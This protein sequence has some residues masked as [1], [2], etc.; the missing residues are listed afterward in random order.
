M[1][2]SVAVVARRSPGSSVKA[3]PGSLP[4]LSRHA[5]LRDGQGR[6]GSHEVVAG[7]VAV[8]AHLTQDAGRAHAGREHVTH[9]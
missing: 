7:V 4:Q 1:I 3:S 5:V 2:A 9:R 6:L 8:S